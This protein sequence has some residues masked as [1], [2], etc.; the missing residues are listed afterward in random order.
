[1]FVQYRSRGLILKKNDRGEVD[2]LFT[3]YTKNFGKLEILGKGIKKISSK[4]R[5]GME[6]FYLSEIEFI[7]GKRYKT[8]TDALKI[9]KFENLRKDL[10]RLAVAYKISEDLNNLVG[11]EEPDEKIWQL[12]IE[13]FKKLNNLQLTTY[14]LQLIYYYFF[15]NLISILGYKPELYFCP[16][17]QKKLKPEKLYFSSKEGGVI[18]Q[19]CSKTAKSI[20]EIKPEIVKILRKIL[21]RDWEIL[22]KL[23]IEENYLKSLAKISQNYSLFISEKEHDNMK[24]DI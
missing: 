1:M 8:L 13:V 23:K 12:L 18:C 24:K 17:C 14:N 7:Q 19:N 16:L 9:E 6:I 5:A 10:K 22:S 2:Q 20:I 15:W 11:G 3:I 4:L 21:E